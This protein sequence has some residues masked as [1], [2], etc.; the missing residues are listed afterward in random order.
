MIWRNS[1]LPLA[2]VMDED[3][4]VWLKKGIPLTC[5]STWLGL[6]HDSG[7]DLT[8]RMDS[9]RLWP[10]I[11]FWHEDSG[12][13]TAPSY[14]LSEAQTPPTSFWKQQ[15]TSIHSRKTNSTNSEHE[16]FR[17]Q[18]YWQLLDYSATNIVCICTTFCL[19]VCFHTRVR[20]ILR[21]KNK[22][23]YFMY[24]EKEKGVVLFGL[25]LL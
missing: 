16:M 23:W 22:L 8:R 10:Q 9:L 12:T 2:I 15:L 13:T 20:L 4:V 7:S 17:T 3:L 18:L 5:D 25:I 24:H 11:S 6:G 21:G 14:R 1:H 19:F